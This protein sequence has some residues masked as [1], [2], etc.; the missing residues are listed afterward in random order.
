MESLRHVEIMLGSTQKDLCCNGQHVDMGTTQGEQ[1]ASRA[2]SVSRRGR[3][4]RHA[5]QL[6]H[7][8]QAINQDPCCRDM[9]SF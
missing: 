1:P 2:D 3:H 7:S 6:N 4:E 8:K 9:K 5:Y